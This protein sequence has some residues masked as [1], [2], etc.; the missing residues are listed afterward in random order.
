MHLTADKN[1]LNNS[2]RFFCSCSGKTGV[3]I[4]DAGQYI[5]MGLK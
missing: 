2:T 5:E 1:G 3:C 4:P